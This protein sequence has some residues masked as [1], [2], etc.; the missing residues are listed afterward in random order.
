MQ[1]EQFEEH[2]ELRKR[3]RDI[4]SLMSFQIDPRDFEFIPTDWLSRYFRTPQDMPVIDTVN[5]MCVHGKMDLDK[6]NEAKIVGC[7]VVS[8]S[9]P[10]VRLEVIAYCDLPLSAGLSAVR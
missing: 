5:L 9:S 8:R 6:L 7:D 3:M 1:R 10:V 4:C 2:I